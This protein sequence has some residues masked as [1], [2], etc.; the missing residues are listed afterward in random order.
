MNRRRDVFV[1]GV[2]PVLAAPEVWYILQ[3]ERGA[4]SASLGGNGVD[5]YASS[6]GNCL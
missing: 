5:L 1:S 3:G 4:S 2:T 6:G